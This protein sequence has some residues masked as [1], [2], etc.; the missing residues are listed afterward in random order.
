MKAIMYHYVRPDSL[1][2]PNFKSLRIDDFEKQLDYFEKEFG[3]VS[4]VDFLRALETGIPPEGVVLTFDDGFKDHIQYVLPAL[5]KRKL[6][7]V[8]YITTGVYEQERLLDVH[9]IHMLLGRYDASIIFEALQSLIT[10]EMLTDQT[11]EAF[12]EATYQLQQNDDF[13][14]LVK[15]S[16]N[17]FIDYKYR[18]QVIDAL[19]QQFFADTP[20]LFAQFYLSKEEIGILEAA[21]MI[22]GS[23][24]V[25]HPVM[26]KLSLEKQRD[27]IE[28]SF[29]FLEGVQPRL[30]PKT[31]CYPYGGFHTFTTQTEQLLTD[32]NVA[33]SFNVE[34]RDVNTLDLKN[35]KQALPRY[36]CNEFPFGSCRN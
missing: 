26:S 34:S 22:V 30:T 7:G 10:S 27:E 11:V 31:F 6:W 23:H 28:N 15:R 33:F 8:F 4:K 17:Y 20:D 13:T 16:L 18:H 3:F 2:L 14:L 5:V 35:R 36:D 19:M 25:S 29:A 32:Q 21:G 12:Q 24:T 1:A 9:N